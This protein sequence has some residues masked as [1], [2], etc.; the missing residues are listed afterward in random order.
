MYD[1]KCITTTVV[2][3]IIIIIYSIF[4]KLSDK[5]TEISPAYTV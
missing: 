4:S 5:D 2:F 1:K 3:L